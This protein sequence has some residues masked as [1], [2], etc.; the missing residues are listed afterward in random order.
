MEYFLRG[1]PT[2]RCIRNKQNGRLPTLHF[3]PVLAHSVLSLASAH[4]LI[5]G[6]V[7]RRVVC[8]TYDLLPESIKTV[9]YVCEVEALRLFI[10]HLSE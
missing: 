2:H 4:F 10:M 7:S 8:I 1:S 6:R 3:P 9:V 5:Q